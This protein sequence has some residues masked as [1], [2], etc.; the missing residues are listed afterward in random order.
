MM[1]LR[2]AN[3]NLMILSHGVP[4]DLLR[5]TSACKFGHLHQLLFSD[6][7]LLVGGNVFSH[8]KVGLL[9]S[10]LNARYVVLVVATI[11]GSALRELLLL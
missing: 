2:I 3:S 4:I 9:C 10:G 11:I 8:E 1:L 7:K 6:Q 5:A